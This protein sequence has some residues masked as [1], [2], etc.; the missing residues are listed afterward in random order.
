MQISLTDIE[1]ERQRQHAVAWIV[2]LTANIPLPAS[3][4]YAQQVLARHQRGELSLAQVAALLSTSVY[5][6]LYRSRAT[7][8]LSAVQLQELMVQARAKNARLVVSGMLLYSEGMFVQVLEG[9]EE[10]VRALYARIEQD[11]RHT[12]L[13]TVSEGLQPAR[14]FAE[15]S[16]DFG[17]VEGPEVERVLGAIKGQ[18][19]LPELA[20]VNARLQ[21]LLQ[22]FL[23]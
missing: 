11:P 17:V 2:S 20:I 9:P 6:M 8:H 14:Q 7:H 19:R 4:R 15:W 12:R 13:Q 18:Q 22:A 1:I 21:T 23:D 16:M 5:R 10:A 3:H